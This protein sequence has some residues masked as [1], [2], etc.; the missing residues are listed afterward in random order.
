MARHPGERVTIKDLASSE[1]YPAPYIEKILRALRLR[2]IVDSYQG[3]QGGYQ[4]AREP[5][6]ITFK[7]IVEALEGETF[8][9][10]CNP[11]ARGEN[12][13]CN[14]SRKCEVAPIWRKTKEVI[15][16][17]FSSITLEMIAANQVGQLIERM[18]YEH[19]RN[20]GVYNRAV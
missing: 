2:K 11:A 7:E 3:N 10:F 8:D 14:H 9:V 5:G 20:R 15:D 18:P 17:L 19:E 6:A 16:A 13:I 4:L 12:L 1:N